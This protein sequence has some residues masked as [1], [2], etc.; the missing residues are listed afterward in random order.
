MSAMDHSLALVARNEAVALGGSGDF[1]P[2]RDRQ[3][4][5]PPEHDFRQVS[6]E[7]GVTQ[8][9]SMFKRWTTFPPVRVEPKAACELQRLP[10]I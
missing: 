9:L 2:S 3:G 8:D 10:A 6:P 4:A 5:N 1:G 7:L